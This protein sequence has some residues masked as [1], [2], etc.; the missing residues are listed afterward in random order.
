MV[1][2]AGKGQDGRARPDLNVRADVC[3]IA[4]TDGV[5]DRRGKD[6]HQLRKCRLRL[7]SKD[8][9]AVKALRS[10][11]QKQRPCLCPARLLNM[12]RNSK[13]KIIRTRLVKRGKASYHTCTV[14]AHTAADKRGNLID[15]LFHAY[16]PLLEF[17]DHFVGN[18]HAPRDYARIGF[19]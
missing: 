4:H 1:V 19:G 13:G 3:L 7:C 11:R 12:R 9:G 18:V 10:L 16:A 15:C 5:L 6:R 14:T 2:D 8:N 17:A